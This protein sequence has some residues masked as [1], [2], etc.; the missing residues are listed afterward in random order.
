MVTAEQVRS[1]A[2]SMPEAEEHE[3]WAKPSFRVRN[4]I[5][6]VLQED[7]VSLVLKT[8]MDDRTAFTTMAPDIF[9]MPGS[10]QNLA[11]VV[12]RMDRIAPSEC[13][14]MIIQAW[15]LVSP[16]RLVAAYGAD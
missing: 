2:L 14:A 3:H 7:G 15:R 1:W 4:K 13:R 5:F 12:V 9:S 10:F 16:K 11:Y 6:A 8:T